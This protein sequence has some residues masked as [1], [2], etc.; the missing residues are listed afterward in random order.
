MP[1]RPLRP[2]VTPRVEEAVFWALAKDPDDRPQTAGDFARAL[3]N[4]S[5]SRTLGG[6]LGGLGAWRS[7]TTGRQSATA[8][9]TPP[10]TA[11][12]GPRPALG[13]LPMRAPASPRLEAGGTSR[14][15]LVSP[16][17]Q[18]DATIAAPRLSASGSGGG[19][20]APLWPVDPDRRYRPPEKS[21]ATRKATIVAV[22]ASCIAVVLLAALVLVALSN[23]GLGGSP[24]P[25]GAGHP[26]VHTTPTVTPKPTATPGPVDWL[27]V[28]PTSVKL[29]CF[30]KGASATVKLK[31]VGPS[32]LEWTAQV[33]SQGFF[34]PS[35]V[36]VS[37]SSGELESGHSTSITIQNSSF[38]FTEQQGQIEFASQGNSNAGNA[39]TVYFDTCAKGD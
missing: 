22:A 17:V 29:G 18:D 24:N 3:L 5:R 25:A 19:G 13:T 36:R 31:N 12:V 28:S 34:S 2:D 9:Q 38:N 1:L 26:V 27:T 37:P 30:R 11:S 32:T 35:P 16:M 10:R 15:G 20:G 23:A 8:T 39:A 7:Q 6:T 33:S 14:S 21:P 4:A